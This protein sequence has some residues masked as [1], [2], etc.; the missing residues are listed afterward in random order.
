MTS[1]NH[2]ERSSDLA[3][4]A[5]GIRQAHEHCRAA[6]SKGLEHAVEA[7][8]LLIQAQDRVGHGQGLAVRLK[9]AAAPFDPGAIK[10]A[11]K[12]VQHEDPL[13]KYIRL[14]HNFSR[15]WQQ[16]PRIRDQFWSRLEA[17]EMASGKRRR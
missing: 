11:I 10:D 2:I 4:L 14:Q 7:G 6:F 15:M 3:V 1:T 12:G 16:D 5:K 13:I 17:L 9:Q 8:R